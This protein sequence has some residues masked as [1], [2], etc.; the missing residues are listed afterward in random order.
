MGIR[1]KSHIARLHISR[2]RHELVA[3]AIGAVHVLNAVL[4]AEIVADVVVAG[5]IELAGRNEVV[6]NEHGPVRIPD[7]LKAH[8]FELV[9]Y[10]GNKNIVDHD[11]VHVHRD[12]VAG[13]DGGGADVM[14]ENLFNQG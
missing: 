10:K 7:L 1:A 2:L 13:L 11:A 5:V 4:V 3:D 6:V 14:R 12:D 9:F 8:L